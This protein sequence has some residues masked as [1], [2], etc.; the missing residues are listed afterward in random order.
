MKNNLNKGIIISLVSILSL[1]I[2]Y[3]LFMYSVGYFHSNMMNMNT[4]NNNKT[5][6][7]EE[8]IYWKDLLAV[9]EK[10][11]EI[12]N[13]KEGDNYEI[14]IVKIKKMIWNKEVEMLS[15]NGS[16]PGPIIKTKV[17]TKAKITIV[18]KIP[19]LE[20]TLHSHLLMKLVF[21]MNEYFGIIHI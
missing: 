10:K 7:S 13:L 17:W 8:L 6:S 21:Q 1:I 3:Y 16:I 12:V 2:F 18:N 11:Q 15:Y 20:T 19:D 9:Q 5:I 4:V 14:E